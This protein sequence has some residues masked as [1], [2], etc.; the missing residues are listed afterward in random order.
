[1]VVE[2]KEEAPEM[3]PSTPTEYQT[4][5]RQWTED[6]LKVLKKLKAILKGLGLK[7][8][9]NKDGLI[10]RILGHEEGKYQ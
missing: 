4:E 5:Q 9:G 7:K 10:D 8:S 3:L 1:M 6:S 2:Y